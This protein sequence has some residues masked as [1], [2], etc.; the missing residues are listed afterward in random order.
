MFYLNA[1]AIFYFLLSALALINGTITPFYY[2]LPSLI[3]MWACF[4]LFRWGAKTSPAVF[5]MNILQ[6]KWT[7][8]DRKS[9][10]ILFLALGLTITWPLYIEF[11]T[12][13]SVIQ[14]IQTYLS[15]DSTYYIYQKYF[16]DSELREL[17]LTKI[18]YI[19]LG[20]TMKFLF[21]LSVIRLVCFL[22]RITPLDI[23]PVLLL[24]VD[25]AL[26]AIARGTFFE[27]FEVLVVFFFSFFLRYARISQRNLPSK[28]FFIFLCATTSILAMFYAFN[29]SLRYGGAFDWKN[30][31]SITA[32]SYDPNSVISIICPPL[33]LMTV[34]LSAYF[35][36]GQYFTSI[37]FYKI[38]CSNSTSFL[39]ALIPQGRS[40]FNLAETH[41]AEIESIGIY[42]GACWTPDIISLTEA[43][44]LPLV[45]CACVLLGRYSMH[46]ARRAYSDS[47]VASAIKLYFIT[48]MMFAL[49]IGNFFITSSSNILAFCGA[50]IL[51]NSPILKRFFGVL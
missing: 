40:F 13:Q 1:I 46:L 24:M 22:K 38:W 14:A 48:L 35:I 20:G 41:R 18:P 4:F 25:Y 37:V 28:K 36:F 2:M 9:L 29:I 33:A 17:S 50:Y 44:G 34:Q 8:R 39:A 27:Y 21:V 49:P 30:Q 23:I 42:T 5:R 15:G 26:L 47:C 11:Y 6:V 16:S 31:A 45:L 7:L 51:A 10:W 12:G 32:L 19:L 43:C 3:I